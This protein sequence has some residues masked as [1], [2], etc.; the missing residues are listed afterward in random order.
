MQNW[1]ENWNDLHSL[2]EAKFQA[3]LEKLKPFS[4]FH[5]TGQASRNSSDWAFHLCQE[6]PFLLME[7]H[8]VRVC[9]F[10]TGT[11]LPWLAFSVQTH[12]WLPTTSSGRAAR[13][14]PLVPQHRANGRK[15]Q[16]A[17]QAYFCD[18]AT[19]RSS[20]LRHLFSFSHNSF[21]DH[22]IVPLQQARFSNKIIQ[23]KSP[24]GLPVMLWPFPGAVSFKQIVFL[25]APKALISSCSKI[26]EYI[27]SG[28]VH[29]Q[30]KSFQHFK[31]TVLQNPS[32]G[33]TY[34]CL[35][36]WVAEMPPGCPSAWL[37]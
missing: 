23:R 19:S 22:R 11:I 36:F 8:K 9:L 16:R 7:C 15:T 18:P 14:G 27:S 10:N 32:S 3:I 4:R 33:I 6:I 34:L 26:Q 12:S 28:R 13:T 30:W 5:S 24:K 31:N 21:E 20:Q 35:W 1:K 2:L 17:R 25:E 37:L 29:C